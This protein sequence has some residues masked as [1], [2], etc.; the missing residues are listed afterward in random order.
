MLDKKVEKERTLELGQF[1]NPEFFKGGTNFK[2]LS[3]HYHLKD[4]KLESNSL[5]LQ[6][7]KLQLK[8]EGNLNLKDNTTEL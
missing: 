4:A 1:N 3:F 2:L 8:G 5:V 6:T 7:D